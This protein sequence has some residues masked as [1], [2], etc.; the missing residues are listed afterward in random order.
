MASATMTTSKTSSLPEAAAQE[1]RALVRRAGR[2]MATDVSVQIVA[3]PGQL[4]AA[5]AAADACMAWF[6]EVDRTLSR[7]KPESELSRLNAATGR[8]FAASSLLFEAVAC[9]F[10]A[11]QSSDGLFDPTLLRQIEALGY[12]RDFA[13]IA[14]REVCDQEAAAPV[15]QPASAAGWRSIE[16]DPRRQRIRLHDGVR[17]DLGGIAKG[18]A[19]DVALSRFCEDFPGALINVG[20]DLR[21][22]GGPAPGAAWSIGVRDPRAEATRTGADAPTTNVATVTLS[23]GGLATSGALQRW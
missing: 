13:Q 2:P 21:L 6:D 7:F 22:R 8:W 10:Q 16:L 17:L 4:P 18:W 19:A 20:G 9:A 23:R 14:H 3:M 5:Y 1:Q 15:D 12:D 11:A